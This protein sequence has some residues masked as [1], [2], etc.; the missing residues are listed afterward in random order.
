M[1]IRPNPLVAPAT[2]TVWWVGALIAATLVGSYGM[3]CV[4]PFAALATVAAWGLSLRGGMALMLGLWATNQIVGFTLLSYPHTAYSYGWGLALGA[5][6]I[7]G[8]LAARACAAKLMNKN[9]FVSLL[10][11]F[12]AA[13][14]ANQAFG[15]LVALSPLGGLGGFS[16]DIIAEVA[17]LNLA[18]LTLWVA[19]VATM[20]K[21]RN[22]APRAA[23]QAAE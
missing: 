18:A 3:G 16:P 15:L 7:A 21:L 6:G 10:A 4:L 2:P 13:L 11:S 22:L 9:I 5:A 1:N 8:L 19:L 17:G 14:V 20:K 23:V 12:T